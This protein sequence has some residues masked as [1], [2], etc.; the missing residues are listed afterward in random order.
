MLCVKG[1]GW[2][3]N[4][5]TRQHFICPNPESEARMAPK[6]KKRKLQKVIE[7]EVAD[8][9]SEE[10]ERDSCMQSNMQSGHCKSIVSEF[11]ESVNIASLGTVNVGHA[12][13]LLSDCQ[14]IFVVDTSKKTYNVVMTNANNETKHTPLT[15]PS[16]G[17]QNCRL[18]SSIL[19]LIFKNS[20]VA[21]C[22]E[23]CEFLSLIDLSANVPASDNCV[24]L[25]EEDKV[26]VIAASTT[27][28]I[29]YGGSMSPGALS[30]QVY[31]CLTGDLVASYEIPFTRIAY[32][33]STLCAHCHGGRLMVSCWDDMQLKVVDL[34]SGRE[35]YTLERDEEHES[36]HITSIGGLQ[37]SVKAIAVGVDYIAVGYEWQRYIKACPLRVYDTSSGERVH[38]LAANGA[39]P[40]CLAIHDDDK[41]LFSTAHNQKEVRV[42]CLQQ[43]TKL[44]S[45]PCFEKVIDFTLRMENNTLYVRSNAAGFCCGHSL[46]V[47]VTL[48][49]FND[50]D[51]TAAG[52]D[53]GGGRGAEG[54][55][56]IQGKVQKPAKKRASRI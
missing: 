51:S 35:L 56:M 16:D 3:N 24:V 11:S 22:R 36:R 19:L 41:L 54:V 48:W 1:I 17:Y 28:M 20:L 43:G 53:G 10:E 55:V 18:S 15:M 26:I 44:Y 6:S 7:E 23:T 47:N 50:T 37:S 2:R 34:Q 46:N 13:P 30:C 38:C 27:T 21:I 25:S 8:N 31:T 9:L 29:P 32:F 12:E 14:P 4:S 40:K 39:S 52:N 33:P 45:I 49:D 5:S 42:Y